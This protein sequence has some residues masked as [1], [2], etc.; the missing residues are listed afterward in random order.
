LNFS[1]KIC[2]FTGY[3]TAKLFESLGGKEN[4]P[5]LKDALR[6]EVSGLI[7]DDF[8]VFQ[9]GMALGA[10]MLFADV[11]LEFQRKYPR[12]KLIAVIP[13]RGQEKSWNERQQEK[14]YYLLECA[15]ETRLVSDA[16]Y[17]DGCMLIRN[18]N[19]VETCDL[20]LAVYDGKRGGTMQTVEYAKKC[21][22]KIRI[23][24]PA[25]LTRITLFE[26]IK[27]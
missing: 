22:K 21:N 2:S 4:L 1:D 8:T 18:K 20:L 19:L 23:I 14:Y 15:G 16:E 9:C 13:C 17:F 5:E 11:V 24:D 12:V 25:T 6:E 7:N 27:L 3:R 26:Q 10:D